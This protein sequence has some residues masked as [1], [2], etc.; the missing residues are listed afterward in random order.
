MSE[1]VTIER[2]GYYVSGRTQWGRVRHEDFPATPDGRDS[3]CVLA[4]QWH[5]EQLV[6]ITVTRRQSTVEVIE[7]WGPQLPKEMQP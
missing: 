3:A 6:E 5:V 2:D 1:G 7:R 4:R